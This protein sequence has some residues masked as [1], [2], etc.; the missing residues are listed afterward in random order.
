MSILMPRFVEKYQNTIPDWGPLGEIVFSIFY[1]RF[2][3]NQERKETWVDCCS[4]VVTG[5]Y[6]LQK[7]HC[8][9]NNRVWDDGKAIRDAHKMFELLFDFKF[10]PP[11]RG[12][13]SMGTSTVARHGG[14]PLNNCGFISTKEMGNGN[15]SDP[16][17]WL[18]HMSMLGVGVGFD[19]LG[20]G[21]VSVLSPILTGRMFRIPDS[22]EG[23]VEAVAIVLN[24]YFYGRELPMFDFWGIRRQGEK[25]KGFGGTAAGPGPLR[26]LLDSLKNLLDEYIGKLIDSRCIVDIMNL[27]GRCV[28]S[29]NVRRSAEIAIG[30]YG[31]WEFAKLKL[32]FD[33][34]REYRYISNNSIKSGPWSDYKTLGAITAEYGE[35]GYIFLENMRRFGRM[36]GVEYG[37]DYGA[38]GC[39]PCVEQT[40]WH[41]ELCNLVELFINRHKNLHEYMATAKVAYRYAKTV[42]LVKTGFKETDDIIERHRRIG[43]SQSGVSRAFNRMGTQRVYDWSDKLYDFI[44]GLDADYSCWLGINRSIKRTSIKPSGTI[45]LL[46]GETSALNY[47]E[48]EFYHRTIRVS[49]NDP[50]LSDLERANYRIEPN[51]YG[52]DGGGETMV[53]YVPVHEQD[54]VR[55]S[56]DVSMWEQLEHVAGM[57]KYWADNQVSCTITFD[58]KEA[59]EIPLAL[60]LYSSRLKA[61]SFLPKDQKVYPQA[62]IQPLTEQEYA[63]SLAQLKPLTI[64][65]TEDAKAVSGC[66]GGS[67]SVF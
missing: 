37:V 63:N 31:D 42:S 27:I 13:W 60:E 24:A 18:M 67:C 6:D 43:C 38:D 7:L 12:L 9:E 21:K 41:R 33:K 58:E 52:E 53:V 45:P 39:N 44:T 30:E 23:W 49:A 55:A 14:A 65:G 20:A 5:I 16:F 54:F 10:L 40:L 62:P 34:V 17:C 1:S 50:I 32:D 2:L 22:R 28:V 4:R 47:P 64:T 46:P 15:A 57:Q 3:E 25:I 19:T 8:L 56:K 29:G 51:I 66:D 61:V 26:T 35:P 48:S 59:K 11:G 36:N